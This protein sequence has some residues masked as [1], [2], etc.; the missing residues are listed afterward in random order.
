MRTKEE[1]KQREDL[2]KTYLKKVFEKAIPL[3]KIGVFTMH[4]SNI[5]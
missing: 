2:E 4:T 1:Q 3:R 5:S